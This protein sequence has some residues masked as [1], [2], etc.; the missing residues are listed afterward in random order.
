MSAA[1]KRSRSSDEDTVVWDI[2]DRPPAADSTR[3]RRHLLPKWAFDGIM[4]YPYSSFVTWAEQLHG[5][6]LEAFEHTVVE[7]FHR[8]EYSLRL[9]GGYV[10]PGTNLH[11]ATYVLSYLNV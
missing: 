1:K 3:L 11:N 2:Y 10:V 6:D 8:F 5:P 9:A 4:R 7:R